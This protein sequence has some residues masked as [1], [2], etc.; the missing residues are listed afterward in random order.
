MP[1]SATP[2]WTAG[3][4]SNYID[5]LSDPWVTGV[6]NQPGSGNAVV[7]TSGDGTHP[8]QAGQWNIAYHVASE[9]AKRFPEFQPR[10]GR[11]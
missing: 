4:G 8:T 3:I 11:R 7:Y 9:L 5:T 6:W 1:P 10:S 2:V